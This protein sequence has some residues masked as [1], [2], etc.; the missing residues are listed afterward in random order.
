MFEIGWWLVK[1]GGAEGWAPSNYLQLVPAKPKIA[2]APAPPS[3][4]ALPPAP[5][6]TTSTPTPQAQA[7]PKQFSRAA[8]SSAQPV[9]V[10]PGMGNAGGLQAILAAKRAAAAGAEESNASSENSSPNGSR[11]SS[12]L[13]TSLSLLLPRSRSL[14]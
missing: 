11:P 12:G 2:P 9:S 5:S 10:M 14:G 6:T 4:R 8:E 3:R 13:G 7:H 1:K